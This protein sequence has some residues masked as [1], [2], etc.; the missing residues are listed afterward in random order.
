MGDGARLFSAFDPK[1]T[2]IAAD[3]NSRETALLSVA[4]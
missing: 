4:W 2:I 3:Q 1:P